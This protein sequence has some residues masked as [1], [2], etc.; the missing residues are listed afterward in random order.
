MTWNFPYLGETEELD[1]SSRASAPGDFVYLNDGYTHYQI[2][3]PLDGTPVVLVHGFSVPYFIWD[4]TFN[5]LIGQ[6]FRVLRFDLYGRGLSDR[7]QG[8]Y[9]INRFCRQLHGL[10][11]KLQIRAPINLIGLSMGGPIT[12][13]YAT[14]YPESIAKLVLIDPAG[15]RPIELS[16]ALKFATLPGVGELGFGL[17]GSETLV[18]SIATDFFGSELV[19][20]FQKQFRVQ[21]KYKGFKR[22]ILSTIRNGLLGDFSETYHIVGTNQIPVL[23]IWGEQDLTVPFSHSEFIRALIPTVEFHAIKNCGHIPHYE[24][25]EQVNPILLKF[26]IA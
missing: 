26:L 3:G 19:E 22:A 20:H 16:P 9:D 1:D 7:P 25:P 5:F 4:P 17:F 2:A 10:I 18:K 15:A 23:L 12:A 14:S 11:D 8:H 6:G 24:K 13:T 21:M